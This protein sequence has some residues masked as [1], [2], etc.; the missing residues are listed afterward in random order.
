MEDVPG[1]FWFDRVP[2]REWQ[3]GLSRF[4]QGIRR[5]HGFETDSKKRALKEGISI[6]EE[7]FTEV[8]DNPEKYKGISNDFL[9][10]QQGMKNAIKDMRDRLAGV[11]KKLRKDRPQ[12]DDERID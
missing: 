1:C 2:R 6:F 10:G 9:L 11:K 4:E 12:L 8:K 5:N 7:L 3:I